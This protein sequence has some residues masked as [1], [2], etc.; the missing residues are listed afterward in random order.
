MSLI[1]SCTD[2]SVYAASVYEHTAWAAKKLDA[3]VQV[4]HLLEPHPERPLMSDWSGNLGMDSREQLMEELVQLEATQA[5]IAQVKA[6]AILGEA[7]KRL[8][9]LG[10]EQVKTEALHGALVDYIEQSATAKKAQMVV[11]GKRGESADF[12]KLHLG[13]NLERVIRSCPHPVLVSARRYSPIQRVLIAFDGG[14]SALKAVD[15]AINS[16]LLKGLSIALLAAGSGNSKLENQLEEARQKF[17]EAGFEVKAEMLPG[18]PET[19][20]SN[21]VKEE[22]ID[23]LLMGAYGHSRIRQFIVGSTTTTMIR[24]CQIPILMFR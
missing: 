1:L 19:L 18:E 3:P 6:N 4:I 5:R 11:I 12:A 2:G 16:P 21:R 9:E 8:S 24:T 7:A 15:Y 14:P 10:L 13:G 20:I 23:L 22:K 17:Q